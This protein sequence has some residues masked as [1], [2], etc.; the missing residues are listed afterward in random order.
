MENL[1]NVNNQKKIS[2]NAKEV[3]KYLGT[4]LSWVYKY[5]DE[6]GVKKLGGSLF[7]PKK[8]ELY[9]RLFCKEKGM[10]IR[11]H[12]KREQVH[13]SLVHNKDLSQTSR[14]KKKRTTKQ[15]LSSVAVRDDRN[16]YGLLDLM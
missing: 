12:S 2:S 3:A 11:L 5:Q 6:L 13:G 4:S 14:S 15:T 16:R 9:E 8:E 10:E 1:L 7:F